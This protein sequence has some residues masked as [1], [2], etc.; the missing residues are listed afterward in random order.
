MIHHCPS[1][2]EVLQVL[3]IARRRISVVRRGRKEGKTESAHDFS[4]RIII[5]IT[6]DLANH[7]RYVGGLLLDYGEFAVVMGIGA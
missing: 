1:R 5:E 4:V 6:A 2:I 3:V 7:C